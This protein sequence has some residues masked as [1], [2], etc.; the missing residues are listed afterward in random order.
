[1]SHLRTAVSNDGYKWRYNG[2]VPFPKLEAAL[3]GHS[4][5]IPASELPGALAE[6]SVG[7]QPPHVSISVPMC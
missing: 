3:K 4:R 1:M 6:T 2:L 7:V 5:D